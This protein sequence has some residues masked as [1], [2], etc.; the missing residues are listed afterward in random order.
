MAAHRRA[1]SK[2][3][4]LLWGKVLG[5]QRHALVRWFFLRWMSL[6]YLVAFLSMTVQMK[7]LIGEN[8]LLP[9]QAFLNNIQSHLGWERC[10]FF[11]TLAWIN[12]SDTGIYIFCFLGIA[13]SFLV[14]LRWCEGAG[15]LAGW[16]LYL[17]LCIVGQSFFQFQWDRL[18]L[19]AGFLAIFLGSWK[20]KP[21][22]KP[23]TL[24]TKAII[25]LLRWL[26]FR[27]MFA[28][29][30]V[31]LLSEDI[32]WQGFTALSF[33]YETQPL[34]TWIGWFIH[35]LPTSFHALSGFSV[36]VIELFIPLFIFSPR[37]LR[38]TAF[39]I[40]FGFQILI[41]LT[42]NY[43]FFNWLTIGLCL[44]LLDDV[45]FQKILPKKLPALVTPTVLQPISHLHHALFSILVS[46]ILIVTSLR[47]T[48]QF[49]GIKSLNRWSQTVIDLTDPLRSFN[50]YGL[51]AI[52]TTE[53]PEIIIEGSL[54]GVLW[55]EYRFKW[56]PDDV[57]KRPRIIA[58]HQP[59][60]DWQMWFA[61][62]DHPFRHPWLH[63]L[64]QHL[65]LETPEVLELLDDN[66][67]PTEP[68]QQV[69][70]L[71]Y[72][73]QFSDWKELRQNKAWWTR[74]LK[75]LYIAPIY[76]KAEK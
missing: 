64:M 11:P 56:K 33:H 17:S 76:L 21:F 47:F 72:D 20:V 4:T 8:G 51:F 25:W 58:P 41:L 13:A 63:R 1:F 18:L 34:P 35:Q 38:L 22:V 5:P 66:P 26:L 27:L 67:F 70:A 30:A 29:G 48:S 65:L 62:L 73:Y 6:M 52:M 16:L 61:A 31:K 10:Y 36:L 50:R 57:T 44:T 75:G 71:L 28:S 40:L 68:P 37:R 9:A 42:G 53:R 69:R 59:R 7:G 19:E 49:I 23:E 3:T 2:L 39:F 43:G 15:L 45:H 24:E 74:E 32:S 12:A 55:E 60:L 14:L 54:D 46:F